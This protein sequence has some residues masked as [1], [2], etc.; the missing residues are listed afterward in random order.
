MREAEGN[1]QA[2]GWRDVRVSRLCPNTGRANKED[3]GWHS[4]AFLRNG[5]R[6]A[7]KLKHQPAVP[8]GHIAVLVE[9]LCEKED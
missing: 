2:K 5:G 9:G 4:P 8:A 3:D 6:G 7:T 1:D